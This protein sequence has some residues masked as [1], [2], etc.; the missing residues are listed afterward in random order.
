KVIDQVRSKTISALVYP[1]I[2]I[3][4]AIFL[5]GVITIKVVPTFSEFY[6]SFETELPLSTRVIVA[7]SDAVRAQWL[8][9]LTVLGGALVGGYLWLKRA[10]ERARFDRLLLRL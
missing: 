1:V 10:D 5:V 8:L 2:L 6:A 4:L 7:V 3:A 9:L